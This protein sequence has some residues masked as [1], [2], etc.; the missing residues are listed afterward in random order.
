MPVLVYPDPR[1]KQVSRPVESF[2]DSLREFLGDLEETL[3]AGPAAVG[4]AAPQV[5]RFERIVLVDV[6]CKPKIPNH[7]RL[8]LINPEFLTLEGSV[9]GREGCLSVPDYTGNVARAERIVVRARDEVGA[10]REYTMTGFEARAV[11]HEVDHLEGLLFL[12]RLV[13]R[14]DGLFRRKV[15]K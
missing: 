6:S 9:V 5:G 10:E 1:L 2:D 7:G 13:S 15:Y 4:I 14:R 12:D 8:V 11:Q 3:R